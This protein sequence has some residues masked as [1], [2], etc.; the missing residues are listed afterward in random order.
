MTKTRKNLG[1]DTRA[2][3]AGQPP[4]PSTGALVTPIYAT[5]TYVQS[6]P[7]EHK[8]FE[9]SRSQNPT[10]FAYEDCIA[11]LEDGLAGFAFASGLSASATVLDLLDANFHVIALDDLYGGS[12][13]L[14]EQVRRRSAGLEFSYTDMQ[15]RR[16]IEA[17]VRDNTRMIWLETPS[18]PLLNLVDLEMVAEIA[19]ERGLIAVADNTF[20]T[21]WAQRPIEFGFDLVLHSATKYLN[22]HSDIIGGIV[23]CGNE[24]LTEPLRFLQNAVGAIAS[25]FDCFLAL[26][27]LKTLGIRMER[28]TENATIIAQWLDRHPKIERVIYPGLPSHPQHYLARRQMSGY[29]GMIAAVLKGGVDESR[30]F[31]E[32]CELFTLAESLGGVESLI[33]HPAIMTHASVPEEVRLSLGITEGLVRISVGIED[34]DDLIRDLDSALAG[35]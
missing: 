21:P 1:F 11:S 22:G 24:E 18:N 34:V 32:R 8:G 29:G 17:L 33:E 15:T 16:S 13:R 7:G 27:G 35:I 2:I 5:S 26:R 23:V 30:R 10:R 19:G 20:A 28:H 31:L 6:A 14:F 12:R 9:Y 4:D 25:P 3:H